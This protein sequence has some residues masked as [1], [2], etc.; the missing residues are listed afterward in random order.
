MN[1]GPFHCI[2]RGNLKPLD[3]LVYGQAVMRSDA[4]MTVCV[5]GCAHECLA[6]I[7]WCI[8]SCKPSYTVSIIEILH[9][10]F[11]Y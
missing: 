10:L 2:I 9:F 4:V 6:T 7:S 5:W 3:H 1:T 8:F 11:L